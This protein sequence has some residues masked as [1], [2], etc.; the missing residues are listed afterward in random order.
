MTSHGQAQHAPMGWLDGFAAAPC[1]DAG[2]L[3][4]P[5]GDVVALVWPGHSQGSLARLSQRLLCVGQAQAVLPARLGQRIWSAHATMRALQHR[6]HAIG[7]TLD[8]LGTMRQLSVSMP[9]DLPPDV[10]AFADLRS[11][12]KA[13]Q[14]AA[15]AMLAASTP[16]LAMMERCDVAPRTVIGPVQNGPSR[17]VLHLLFPAKDVHSI[18]QV[19]SQALCVAGACAVVGPLPPFAFISGGNADCVNG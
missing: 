15:Q 12:H 3:C 17:C 18:A 13:R 4:V 11:K 16:L 9:V 8:D 7:K 6:Q 10:P 19:L 14:M 2:H 5:L 1:A